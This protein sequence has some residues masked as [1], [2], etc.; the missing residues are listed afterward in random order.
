MRKAFGVFSIA[1]RNNS[2]GNGAGEPLPN[3]AFYQTLH[4]RDVGT[5]NNLAVDL[6]SVHEFLKNFNAP[7]NASTN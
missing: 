6:T 7:S 3:Q 4:R 1:K 2:Q 5:Q